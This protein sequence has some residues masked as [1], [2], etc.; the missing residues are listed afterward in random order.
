MY[1]VDIGASLKMMGLSSANHKEKM[2]IRQSNKILDIP[3]ASGIVV[4]DTQA[5]GYIKELGVH[6]WV[7]LVKDSP[8]L[9]SLG[10]PNNELD[11]SYSWPTR[12][13]P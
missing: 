5:K 10:R 4:S 9:L 7:H 12:E 2:T 1:T 13:T 8:S 3:T 6:L 11:Y